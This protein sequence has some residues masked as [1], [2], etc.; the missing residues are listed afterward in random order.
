[1]L[2]LSL[3]IDSSRGFRALLEVHI[4]ELAIASSIN[5]YDF[6]SATGCRVR[7][8]LPS[9]LRRETTASSRPLLVISTDPRLDAVPSRLERSSRLGFRR[10]AR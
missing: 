3:T 5:G 1:M 8:L 2:T 4:T 10:L 6:L 9:S 7:L